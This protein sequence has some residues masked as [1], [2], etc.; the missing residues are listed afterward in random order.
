MGGTCSS[1][2][3]RKG[4]SRVLVRKHEEKIHLEDLGVD[5]DIML[6]WIYRK[7]DV[8]RWTGLSWLRIRTGGGHL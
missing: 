7:W 6:R 1:Y 5:G 8:G 4:I 3:E 2:G